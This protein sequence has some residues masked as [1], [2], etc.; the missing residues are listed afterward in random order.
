ME[1]TTPTKAGYEVSVICPKGKG[2]E[3][4]YEVIDQVHIY[5]HPMPPDI[6]SV[7]GYLREYCTALFWGVSPCPSGLARARF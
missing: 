2:F 6:S 5:R 3:E 1:S 4:E 7:S